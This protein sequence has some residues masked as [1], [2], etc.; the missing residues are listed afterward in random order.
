[1]AENTASPTVVLADVY[2]CTIHQLCHWGNDISLKPFAHCHRMRQVLTFGVVRVNGLAFVSSTE[3]GLRTTACQ[4][5]GR[6]A[7]MA[8]HR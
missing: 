4:R 5:V 7:R 2:H 8:I 1:M 6:L 3:Q